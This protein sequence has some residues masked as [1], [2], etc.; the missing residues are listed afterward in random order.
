MRYWAWQHTY[1]A[2]RIAAEDAQKVRRFVT[3]DLE[4]KVTELAELNEVLAQRDAKL[5]EAQQAQADLIRK[6]ASS[7]TRNVRWN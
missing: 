2:I 4:Q 7:T 1:D 3:K 5:A 6:H